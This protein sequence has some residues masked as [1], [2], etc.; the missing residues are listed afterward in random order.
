MTNKYIEKIIENEFQRVTTMN[1]DASIAD[2]AMGVALFMIWYGQHNNYPQYIDDGLHLIQSRCLNLSGNDPLDLH[3]GQVGIALG[4]LY[5][6]SS[7]VISTPISDVLQQV[8][9]NIFKNIIARLNQI[10]RKHVGTLIDIAY[11]LALRL[12]HHTFE[13][14]DHRI[15]SKLLSKIINTIY[16]DFYGA[17]AQEVYPGG[18]SYNLPRFLLLLSC[19]FGNN[20]DSR[21]HRIIDEIQPHVLAQIPYMVSNRL[22]LSNAIYTLAQEKK[23]IHYR[24]MKHAKLLIESIDS[25]DLDY[26]YKANQMSLY[27]GMGW[28]AIQLLYKKE[29]CSILKQKLF[30][31]V[32]AKFDKSCFSNMAYNELVERNFIGLYG[33]LGFIII[34]LKLKKNYENK[35]L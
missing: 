1:S 15:F 6:T 22:A 16:P 24:W 29:Y 9:D 11:Y 8:D 7:K 27:N 5:L 13:E 3:K 28:F 17:L 30:D 12:K 2:G 14:T 31:I 20:F 10:E 18:Y 26:E 4:I 33:I 32:K 23:T 35:L 19:S 34:N 25:T 21:V